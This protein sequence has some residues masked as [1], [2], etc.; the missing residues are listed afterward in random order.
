VTLLVLI[1]AVLALLV[2]RL[3]VALALLLPSLVYLALPGTTPVGQAIPQIV[4]SVDSFLLIA[5]PLF[6]LMG[7]LSNEGGVT[8]RLFGFAQSALAPVRG[9]LGYVNIAVSVGFAWMS[10]AAVADAAGLG[11]LEVPAM[12]RRG[13]DERFAVGITAASSVI[14][15]IMPP[16]IPA[17]LYAVAASV[18]LGGMLIAGIVPAVVIAGMLCGYV[19]WW[20]RDKD[21]LRLPRVAIGQL[22]SAT[23]G[24]IPALLAPVILVGGILGGVFTPT[25]AA[26]VAV[27]YILLLG[28]LDRRLRLPALYRVCLSAAETTGAVLLIVATSAI[29][30][31]IVAIERG[32]S[33]FAAALTGF[34]DNPLLFL[35]LVNVFVLAV[36]TLLDPAS[37]LLILTPVLLPAANQFGIDPLH[38]G[39]ILIFNL[40]IGLLTPPVGL[41]LYV[42]SSV[43]DLP[44]STVVRGTA[45]ALVPLVVAL[46]LI[47]YVPYLTLALP[48]ALGF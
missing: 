11:R 19:W 46:L 45:P 14:G 40:M 10:G 27:A 28:V 8:D 16:S 2:L 39:V 4:G 6:I 48:R 44:F 12:T 47:T 43:T 41:I 31:W 34:T 5:V 38:F 26:A 13:Y 21:H 18:S 17:V 36:G 7:T 29:F 20:A 3:P 33:L 37:A 35:L 15:P 42:L 9:S 23:L 22:A 1:A 30:S 25:E 24:A 32:P